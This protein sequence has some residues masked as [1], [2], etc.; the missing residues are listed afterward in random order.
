MDIY[1]KP[2]YVAPYEINPTAKWPITVS[3]EA[4][5]LFYVANFQYLCTCI[6]FSIS[7]PF[8]K[9][10]WTNTPYFVSIVLLFIFN[11]VD[12]FV[13]ADTP[14]FSWF[15]CLPFTAAGQSYYSYKYFIAAGIFLNSLC[16]Y[17]AEKFI[18]EKVTKSFDSRKFK[19]REQ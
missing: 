10:I 4:T 3:Y 12:L 13:P 5:V 11:T 15:N 17:V 7:K 2:W 8:R 9:E 18:I 14:F 6:S 16:T 1:N 19:K